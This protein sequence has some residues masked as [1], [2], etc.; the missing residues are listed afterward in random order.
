MEHGLALQESI[1]FLKTNYK[2]IFLYDRESLK[3][4]MPFK[5]MKSLE[6]IIKRLIHINKLK[7]GFLYL[8]ITRGSAKRNHLF[9]KST[10][11]NIV[12]FLP[13]IPQMI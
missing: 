10:K 4:K 3:I 2:D 5:N 12:I 8:Q 1:K 11:P 6:L 7:S 9:P 13:K